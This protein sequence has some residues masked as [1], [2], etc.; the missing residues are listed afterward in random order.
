M[1][2]LWLKSLISLMKP[3]FCLLSYSANI[4]LIHEPGKDPALCDCYRPILLLNI[5]QKIDQKD[6]G[7]DFRLCYLLLFTMISLDLCGH[8]AGNNMTKTLN[9]ISYIQKH[10][11]QSCILSFDNKKAFDRVSWPFLHL[12]LEQICLGPNFITKVMALYSSPLAVVSV[13]GT[14]PEPNK[15]SNST[16]QGCPLSPLLFVLVI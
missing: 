2:L 15:I 13:N 8:E 12:S 4:A 10:N 11:L 3:I 9:L 7:L 6:F 14:Y 5:D 16:R 1:L